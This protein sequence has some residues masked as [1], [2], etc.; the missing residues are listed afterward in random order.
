M[1]IKQSTLAAAITAALALSVSQ[2]ASAYVYG[3]SSLN[4]DD[5]TITHGGN[6]TFTGASFNFNLTNTAILNGVGT[7]TNATCTGAVPGTN[8][9]GAAGLRLDAAAA[10]APGSAPV[11]RLNNDPQANNLMHYGSVPANLV[12]NWSNSDT[13]IYGAELLGDGVT[14]ANQIAESLITGNGS[15]SANAEIKST[16]GLTYVFTVIGGGLGTLDLEFTADPDMLAAISG[17]PVGIY[18]AQ[19]NM[20]TS[21]TLTRDG[22]GVFANWN[23]QGTAAEDCLASGVTCTE[24]ADTEDL[25]INVGT[26]TNNDSE[27]H[28]YSPGVSGLGSFGIHMDGLTA[29]TYTLTLN[30]LT[31][32][33]LTRQAVPEPGMLA[34]LGIGMV[35]LGMSMR[36]RKLA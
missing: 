22:G 24:T 13:V 8:N 10:N 31:S 34:L 26:S 28:S 36:R 27:P 18:G 33:L 3:V 9:C 12:G 6:V 7:V 19:A 11:I 35:G 14:S 5:L 20:N 2:Q 29:G 4:I 30:A 15:A 16:T 17:E 25:N 1:S 32:T 23:P 21:F